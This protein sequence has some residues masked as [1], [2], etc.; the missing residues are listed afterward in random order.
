MTPL[1]AISPVNKI[2]VIVGWTDTFSRTAV[3]EIT[4][5]RFFFQA[6]SGQGAAGIDKDIFNRKAVNYCEHLIFKFWDGR[7]FKISKAD[8]LAHCWSYPPLENRGYKANS[9]VF[10][11]KLMISL[12]NLENYQ[13]KPLSKDEESQ[14]LFKQGI[15][16]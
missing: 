11:P 16:S 2:R 12:S 7:K 8:F 3:F 9:G 13:E 4:Q 14:L 1:Y 6:E 10:K 15:L 5:K